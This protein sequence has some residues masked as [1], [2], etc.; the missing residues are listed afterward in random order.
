IMSNMNFRCLWLPLVVCGLVFYTTAYGAKKPGFTLW[1]LP[2]QSSS[3]MNSYV[4]L[5]DNGKLCVMDGGTAA[6]AP[7]LKGFL[8]AMGNEVEAWFITHPHS[9]HIGALNEILKA[10]GNLTIHTVYHSELSTSFVEQYEKGSEALTKE[11]Y[12]RL[13]K[14]DG[15]V[16]D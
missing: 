8:A 4:L 7:Y 14:F 5:T 15:K 3:Q 13:R 2:A 11:F 10:P 12:N 9:D 6:D 16:V 1:Q